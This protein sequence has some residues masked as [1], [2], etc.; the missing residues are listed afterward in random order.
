M[1]ATQTWLVFDEIARRFE[2]KAKL[3][4]REDLR[5]DIILRLAELASSGQKLTLPAML[6]IAS[7]VAQEYWRDLLR[8]QTQVCVFNGTAKPRELNRATCE[9]RHKPDSCK[10][11][12]YIASRPIFT[13]LNYE[14]QDKEGNM[15]ELWQTLADDNAIDFEDWLDARRWLLGC[16]RR[17]VEIAVK[18]YSGKPLTTKDRMYLHRQAKKE[19]KKYQLSLI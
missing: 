12:A 1:I 10:D 14:L 11:C 17:L 3:P 7:Y 4:D 15:V 9:F 18:R 2:H 6:R 13:S 16:P 8:T 5:Q 19:A